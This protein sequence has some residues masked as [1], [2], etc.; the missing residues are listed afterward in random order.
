VVAKK[1]REERTSEERQD[2]PFKGM[3]PQVIYFL[4]LGPTSYI[5][6][7]LLMVH[8]NLNPSID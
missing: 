6:H 7:Y 3:P 4:Q 8:L 5:S 2:I 1:Q